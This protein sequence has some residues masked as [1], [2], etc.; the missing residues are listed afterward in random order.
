[1]PAGQL[2]RASDKVHG[3]ISAGSPDG[4]SPAIS[5]APLKAARPCHSI[6]PKQPHARRTDQAEGG[7]PCVALRPVLASDLPALDA[8]LSALDS[9]A[10]YRRWFTGAT[11]VHRAAAWAADPANGDAVGLVAIAPN[12]ELVGHAALIAM[13]H[14]RAEVCFEVAAP[15]R[16]HG[17]AGRLLAE[18]ERRAAQRGLRTLVA[19]VLVE[20]VEMLAVMREHGPCHEHRDGGV[21]ELELAIDRSAE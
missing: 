10:R 7:T 6:S 20:N 14:A 5:T 19:E 21:I 12:G 15:W 2:P 8:L 4:R 13:D 17:V 9:Q 18:L 16:H 1:M 11:D 3:L